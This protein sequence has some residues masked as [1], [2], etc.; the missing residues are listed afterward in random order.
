MNFEHLKIRNIGSII[1]MIIIIPLLQILKFYLIFLL[2]EEFL[3]I[4]IIKI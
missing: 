2:Y 1:L 4:I 3:Y